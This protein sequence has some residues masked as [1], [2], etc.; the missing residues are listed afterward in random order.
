MNLL[1]ENSEQATT[2]GPCDFTPTLVLG[3]PSRA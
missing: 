2:A 3:E 1:L